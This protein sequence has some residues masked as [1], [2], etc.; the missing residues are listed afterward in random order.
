MPLANA[1]KPALYLLIPQDLLNWIRKWVAKIGEDAFKPHA[2]STS[3]SP[4]ESINYRSHDVSHD[5]FLTELYR[6]YMVL[7]RMPLVG[8]DPI[9]AQA[10]ATR[11][12]E[13]P[14]VLNM[15][16]IQDITGLSKPKVYE[17]AHT[18]GFPLVHFRL[19]MWVPREAFLRWLEQQAGAC[20]ST[21][22]LAQP[23]VESIP[24][25]HQVREVC[26]V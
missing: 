25:P 21:R 16:N 7:Q 9:M 17:L 18:Q 6:V 22:Y 5:L 24:C 14:L 12:D 11:R 13:L 10:T 3:F 26:D 4:Q 15:K 20:C 2:Y 1:G 23:K 8:K 19:Y